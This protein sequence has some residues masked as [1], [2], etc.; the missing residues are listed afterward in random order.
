M[1]VPASGTHL[2]LVE[3][4]HRVRQRHVVEERLALRA[5]RAPRLAVDDHRVSR[6][7]LLDGFLQ[8]CAGAHRQHRRT[9]SQHH[10]VWS[11]KLRQP[12]G[13]GTAH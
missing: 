5:V 13:R 3:L 2:A 9:A 6:N 10:A 11:A 8:I 4:N 12:K 7:R 1:A